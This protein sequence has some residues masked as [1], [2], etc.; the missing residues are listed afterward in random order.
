MYNEYPSLP[1]A[2]LTPSECAPSWPALDFVIRDVPCCPVAKELGA[3]SHHKTYPEWIVEVGRRGVFVKWASRPDWQAL[4]ESHIRCFDG[5]T[6]S[7]L[8]QNKIKLDGERIPFWL[9]SS[10]VWTISA[11]CTFQIRPCNHI[12]HAIV[13]SI[14]MTHAYSRTRTTR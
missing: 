6:V 2:T 1:T 11:V 3:N 4:S 5:T 7:L 10:L 14:D 9:P 8:S 12:P 13:L